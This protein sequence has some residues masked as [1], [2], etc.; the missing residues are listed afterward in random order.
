MLEF[1]KT[2]KKDCIYIGLILIIVILY[3]FKPNQS[4]Q[5]QD[6]QAQRAKLELQVITAQDSLTKL[7]TVLKSSDSTIAVLEAKLKLNHTKYVTIEK[8]RIIRDSVIGSLDSR[9]LELLFINRYNSKHTEKAEIISVADSNTIKLPKEVSVSTARELSEKDALVQENTLL[10]VDTTILSAE[11]TQYK[12]KD[13]TWTGKEKAYQSLMKL[14]ADEAALYQKE[15]K[16]LNHKVSW[17]KT[18]STLKDIGLVGLAI[19]TAI[20]LR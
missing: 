5:L 8:E 7:N 12:V 2:N 1:I 14:N 20:K 17:T 9:E 19:F 4:K 11:I 10:K 18:K 15:I 6:I 16:K 13:A 3:I